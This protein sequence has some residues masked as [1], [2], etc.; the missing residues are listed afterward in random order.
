MNGVLL[1]C[2]HCNLKLRSKGHK[3]FFLTTSH[4]SSIIVIYF[5]IPCS[6]SPFICFR[7][8]NCSGLSGATV[9]VVDVEFREP[10]LPP[11]D[12]SS[13]PRLMRSS[14]KLLRS[15]PASSESAS[16]MLTFLFTPGVGVSVIKRVKGH[17][18][19]RRRSHHNNE[20]STLLW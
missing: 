10:W 13:E 4:N 12:L 1:L 9:E 7:D 11:N 5:S 2:L 3:Y 16:V 20:F 19:R 8:S 15:P 6:I 18:L 14:V 17:K